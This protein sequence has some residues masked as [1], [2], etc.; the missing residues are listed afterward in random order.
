MATET[1]MKKCPACASAVPAEASVCAHCRS[2]L[3]QVTDSWWPASDG[4]LY[5]PWQHPDAKKPERQPINWKIVGAVAAVL[6]VLAVIGAAISD[7]KQNEGSSDQ[8]AV[9]AC[10]EYGDLAERDLYTVA[11][12]REQVQQIWDDARYSTDPAIRD[13]AR[14]ML[15]EFTAGNIAAYAQAGIDMGEACAAVL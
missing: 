14:R 8:A 2:R 13:A 15:A 6:A 10:E 1:A 12:E 3:M 11:E 7:P 9:D 4:L 5:P